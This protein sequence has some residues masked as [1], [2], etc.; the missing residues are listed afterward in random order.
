MSRLIPRFVWAIQQRFDRLCDR[1]NPLLF[2]AGEV[3][4]AT[5][6]GIVAARCT[7]RPGGEGDLHLGYRLRL[8]WLA[9][10]PGDV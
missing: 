3:A 10:S 8:S 4:A 7:P 9:L 5:G 6:E 2:E 1:C